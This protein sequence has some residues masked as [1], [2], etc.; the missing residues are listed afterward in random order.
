M[1]SPLKKGY[2][3]VEEIKVLKVDFDVSTFTRVTCENYNV[4]FPKINEIKISN[5]ETIKQLLNELDCLH[6]VN[7][8]KA[9]NIDV[10][11]QIYLCSK[12]DTSKICIGRFSTYKAGKLFYTTDKLIKIIVHLQY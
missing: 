6:K 3:K 1:I 11:A 4:Y 5:A 12:N 2:Q 8:S 9:I 10:R 7:N